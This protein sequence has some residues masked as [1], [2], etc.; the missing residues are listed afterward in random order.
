M[1]FLTAIFG[2][3]AI[4]PLVAGLLPD[5]TANR[6]HDRIRR[7][8][9]FWSMAS[10]LAAL[11][12]LGIVS[13]HG[14]IV[15]GEGFLPDSSPLQVTL[16]IDSVAALMW[17]L[18][19]TVGWVI[20]RFSRRYLNG[21]ANEGRFLKWTVFTLS[22]VSLTVLSGNLFLS[23]AAFLLT[24]IGLHGLLLH[25]SDR[26]AARFPA[27]LKFFFSRLGDLCLLV[28]AIILYRSFGT[29]D[30]PELFSAIEAS[31]SSTLSADISLSVAAF[32]LAAT[33][34]FKSALFPFHTWLPETMEAPTPVSA[35]MHAGIVNA[36]GYLLI[37][38]APIVVLSPGAMW[39]VAGLGAF[40]A[41]FAAVTMQWQTNVKRS[42]AWSTIAQ[43][44][45]MVLQCGLGAFSAAMLHIIAHSLYKAHAFLNSGSVLAEKKSVA[46]VSSTR[47]SN[48]GATAI[49]M[50][51]VGIAA[52]GICWGFDL[53]PAD[54]PGGVLLGTVLALSLVRW[55]SLLLANSIRFAVPALC[56]SAGLLT[57]YIATFGLIDSVL[58]QG[59]GQVLPPADSSW[60][61]VSI[62]ILASGVFFID[63]VSRSIAESRWYEILYVHGSNGFYVDTFWRHLARTANR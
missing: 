12:S 61:L 25:H 26:P 45:F 20:C 55:V 35:L 59:A 29:A 51:V 5:T 47:G 9:D 57:A 53:S 56:F 19:A 60:L 6:N 32:F 15:V 23:I 54:K 28:A 11:V 43:M 52:T 30:L 37:R 14:P 31:S 62:A 39:T 24:S 2:L 42:L 3:L 41:F 58:A 1:V 50:L 38:V 4:V 16:L 27:N 46:T 21:D 33:A 49:A 34:V 22:A 44:G 13:Q 48:P 8:A 36:G 18:V 63:L 10:M 40:T 17:S 7:V